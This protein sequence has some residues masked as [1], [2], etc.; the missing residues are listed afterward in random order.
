MISWF[1]FVKNY[2]DVASDDIYF[3]NFV[4]CVLLH[5]IES[6]DNFSWKEEIE[7][8]NL[9]I[10]PMINSRFRKLILEI[11]LYNYKNIAN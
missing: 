9:W 7:F 3:G 1:R 10:L 11:I 2:L 6:N 5:E 4:N 8:K